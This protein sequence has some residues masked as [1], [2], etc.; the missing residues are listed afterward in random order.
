MADGQIEISDVNN[1]SETI[2]ELS[3]INEVFSESD[4]NFHDIKTE[5]LAIYS[6]TSI[7]YSETDL[8]IY[9][10]AVSSDATV[11]I[12]GK[13]LVTDIEI[14]NSTLI[15]GDTKFERVDISDSLTVTGEVSFSSKLELTD[16]DISN[17]LIVDGDVINRS[18][19]NVLGDV[20]MQSQVDISDSLSVGGNV[21][22]Y[23]DFQ[24]MGDVS[25]QSHVDISDTLTVSGI[26]T[27]KSDFQVMGDVSMQ[28][29]LEVSETLTVHGNVLHNS[30]LQVVGDVSINNNL[31]V[32][33]LS[34]LKNIEVDGISL[35]NDNIT[36]GNS[37]EDVSFVMHGDLVIKKGGT[38]IVEDD[39]FTI[40]RLQAEVQISNS[41][42][43]SNSGSRCA[44]SV[45]QNDN[46]GDDIVAFNDKDKNVF[47]I[48][49]GGKTFILGDVS[50]T[51]SLDISD[52]L[53]VN[54][55][56]DVYG[57][58]SLNNAIV[59]GTFNVGTV[60]DIE[61]HIVELDI[62]MAKME[63]ITAGMDYDGTNTFFA[64][65]ITANSNLDI[66]KDLNVERDAF[67]NGN[68]SVGSSAISETGNNATSISLRSGD[69]ASDTSLRLGT[70]EHT[71]N[72]YKGLILME[73]I[74]TFS[75]C[76]MHFCVNGQNSNA[77]SATKNDS[78]ISITTNGFVGVGTTT[79]ACE[80]DISGETNISS[81]LNILGTLETGGVNN[82]LNKDYTST[83][84]YSYFNKNISLG[85]KDNYRNYSIG[86]LG[87]N[88]SNNNVLAVTG[89]TFDSDGVSL[90]PNV[91]FA[92][93]HSGNAEIANSIHV[94]NLNVSV[95]AFIEGSIGI[96]VLPKYEL[97]ISGDIHNTGTLFSDSDLNIKKNLVKLD[98]SLEKI[99]N[100][101]G[102]Y[103]HK[104]T[105]D[106]DALKHIGVIAQEVEEEFPEL[107][108]NNTKTKSVNYDGINAVLIECVK[109]LYDENKMLKE[110]IEQ[111]KQ[112]INT[113]LSK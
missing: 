31:N 19:L 99:S 59:T 10:N 94:P 109:Q 8:E 48:S 89:E 43:I 4:L 108:S 29:K 13:L 15:K 82:K 96:G 45:S 88:Y 97:D 65:N 11:D 85:N 60:T 61:S 2:S 32:H 92:I 17:I 25:M 71:H 39:D 78:R 62:S 91:V 93:D 20:S 12:S 27:H 53:Y 1:L 24:V 86:L 34:T 106:D 41:L 101:N 73:A 23:S 72:C 55:N 40:T 30:Q 7:G 102:Y 112:I 16:L 47:K 83:N 66:I 95:S 38:L 50:M 64:K 28:S 87:D 26:V 37:S 81:V 51:S 35:F 68:L 36:F 69:Q 76:N 21:I 42:D 52:T 90:S 105:E 104:K 44:L 103:Y 80:L 9:S 75:K 98:N 70:S 63:I 79:P 67:V 111:V 74:G 56:L 57:L 3:K 5:T 18:K 58:S 33:N 110:E 22:H 14:T 100:L 6:S 49:R 113:H 54:N 107:V 77:I 46:L 84:G